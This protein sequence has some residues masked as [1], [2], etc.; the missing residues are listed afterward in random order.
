MNT[1]EKLYETNSYFLKTIKE[2]TILLIH[3]V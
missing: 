3:W 1:L 2:F